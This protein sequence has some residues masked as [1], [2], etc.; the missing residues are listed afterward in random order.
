[1]SLSPRTDTS[2]TG[3]RAALSYALATLLLA[4]CASG[5]HSAP[6]ASAAPVAAPSSAAAPP[7]AVAATPPTLTGF[8]RSTLEIRSKGGRHWLKIYVAQSE[9]QQ[10]QGLMFVTALPADEGMLFPLDAP[11]VMNMWMKNTLIPLDMLFID[12]KGSIACV[13]A[14]TIPQRLDLITCDK[15]I[16]A[17]LEI[18][19]GQAAARGIVAGDTVIYQGLRRST[20]SSDA[21]TRP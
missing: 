15:P 5:E 9:E 17:V 19:G 10:M 16:M 12:A 6:A 21:P 14:D 2:S 20:A 7:P 13:R 8:A 3:R 1:M 11:R 18:N 4:A